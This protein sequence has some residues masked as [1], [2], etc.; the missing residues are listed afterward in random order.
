[1]TT[2]D[3]AQTIELLELHGIPHEVVGPPHGGASPWSKALTMGGR[4]R[5]LRRW[6]RSRRIDLVLSHAS[7]EPQLVARSLGLPSAYAF[8]YEFARAQHSLGC[9]AARRV[10][11]PDAIPQ[12]RLDRLGAP[13]RKVRRYPGLRR[14][15]TSRA[16]SPT[17]PYSTDWTSTGA[18]SWRSCGRRRTWLCTT[19]TRTRSSAAPCGASAPM[20]TR[21]PSSSLALR[22]SAGRSSSSRSL[23]AGP[24]ARRRRAEPRGALRPRSLRRRHDEPR[25]D[26]TRRSCLHDVLGAARRRRRE[27]RGA[28]EA[29]GPRLA[30]RHSPRE[31]QDSGTTDDRAIPLSCSTS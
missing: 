4:V 25:G 17:R 11:V 31:A 15:T 10:V 28:G 19:G 16:S 27:P 12:Q 21:V 7:H 20:R 3:F 5:A 23:G 18:K 29:R 6:A 22:S 8:D 24:G 30:G 14:S 9:R 13:A 1:M 2:R 26:R